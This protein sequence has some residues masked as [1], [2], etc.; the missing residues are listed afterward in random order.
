[1]IRPM[2]EAIVL[3][4]K[5]RQPGWHGFAAS[6]DLVAIGAQLNMGGDNAPKRAEAWQRINDLHLF[7]GEIFDFFPAPHKYSVC[8]AGDSI[9]VIQEIEPGID[10]KELWPE[11]CGHMYA[12]AGYIHQAE[13]DIDN[14]GLRVI[15][16][17]GQLFPLFQP[18]RWK[19]LDPAISG[20]NWAALTG[21]SEAFKKCFDAEGRGTKGGFDKFYCWHEQIDQPKTFH[22]TPIREIDLHYARRPDMYPEFHIEMLKLADKEATLA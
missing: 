22:G 17:Y 10:F 2:L 12:L 8:F 14:L 18:D 9:F 1:M 5:R 13:Q 19:N 3:E 16:A 20:T 4:A 7:F 21:P 11:F 15:V 6:F